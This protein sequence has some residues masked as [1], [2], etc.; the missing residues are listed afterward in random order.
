[1][2]YFEN[3]KTF[4]VGNIIFGR[5]GGKNSIAVLGTIFHK[6]DKIVSNHKTGEFDREKAKK[7]IEQHEEIAKGF[8]LQPVLDVHAQT[9]E[10]MLKYIEFALDVTDEPII[11]DG[12]VPEIRLPAVRY[13]NEVGA[14]DRIIYD[15]ISPE[16]KESELEELKN[17]KIECAFLLALN[18]SDATPT[19]RIMILKELLPRAEK[20]G[21]TKP[22]LDTIVFDPPSL[23]L[24]AKAIEL[25]KKEFGWPTGNG[26][27]NAIEFIGSWPYSKPAFIGFVTALYSVNQVMGADW[28]FYGEIYSAKYVIPALAIVDGILAYTNKLSGYPVS[29]SR[30]H[31]LYKAMR[32]IRSGDLKEIMR[33]DGETA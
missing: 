17:N 7:A 12:T 22:L 15:A 29:I 18:P 14:N 4:K 30:D 3:E 33:E 16:S 13:V 5:K 6:D 11:I 1:M 31:A 20:F 23:G 9:A 28:L 10:A 19:G 24:A 27:V 26:A 32:V 2:F 21:I 8:G 25:V